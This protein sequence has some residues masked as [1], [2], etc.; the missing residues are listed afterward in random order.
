[1]LEQRCYGRAEKRHSWRKE[2]KRRAGRQEGYLKQE[3]K[4][5]WKERRQRRKG[6]RKEGKE[7]KHHGL[8]DGRK[9]GKK[10]AGSSNATYVVM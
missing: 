6:M 2:A 3:K 7:F 1:M 5:N 9:G 10:D 8:E 4:D